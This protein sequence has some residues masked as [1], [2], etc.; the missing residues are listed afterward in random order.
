MKNLLRV[1]LV[2]VVVLGSANTPAQRAAS[3]DQ[4][5]GPAPTP[6]PAQLDTQFKTVVR[7]FIQT[8]CVTC[9]GGSGPEAG[10]DIDTYASVGAV[11]KDP[12]WSLV[13]ERIRNGEMPAREADRFPTDA[14]R[15]TVAE[16]FRALRNYEITRNA[17]DPGVVLARRL[18]NA[19][20]N[21]TIRDLT[22]VDLQPTR[23]FPSDPSNPAGFDNSGESLTMS[24]AL[25]NKYLKAARDIADHLYLQPDTFAF[26]PHLM[27]SESDRDKFCVGRII[28]FYHRQNTNYL[29]YFEAAWRYK[30]RAALGQPTA[31][32]ARVAA[33]AKV[34]AKYL[35][36]VWDTFETPSDTVGPIAKIQK[37]WRELPP[38]GP[39]KSDTAKQGREAIRDYI[40]RTRKK[41]EPRFA[42]LVA[43]RLDSGQQ[44]FMIWK[45]V[46]YATHRRTFDPA[47][48]QVNGEPWAGEPPPEQGTQSAF[49][50]GKTVFI[51]N[52]A[53]DPDLVVPAGERARYEAAFAKFAS[54][55]PDMFYM[56]E[57][58]RNYFDTTKDRGRYLDAGYHSILGYFRDDQALYE[59]ILEAKGQAE[60]DAMWTDMDFIASANARMYQQFVENGT[61]QAGTKP[62]DI[63]PPNPN[64]EP[65]TT[66]NRIN[67]VK[68]AY[69]K[70]AAGGTPQ[71]I[72]SIPE[73]FDWMNRTLR[74]IDRLKAESEPKHLDVLMKFAGRAYRRP[75]TQV[76]KN[77]LLAYYKSARAEGLNHEA[78]VR[79]TVTSILISP[80][81]LY[82]VDQAPGPG[83]QAPDSASAKATGERPSSKPPSLQGSKPLSDYA[84]ASRLSYF[85]WASM[86]DDKLLARAAA[87]DLHQPA[88]LM[89]EARRML[90]DP[91]ARALAVEFG[92]NWLNFRGFNDIGTVD[93]GRFPEFTND[94]KAAM[95]EEPVRLLMDVF[96]KNRSVLDLVYGTDTFVNAPLAK[97]Y[98]MPFD[99]AQGKPAPSGVEGWVHVTDANK[100]DRGGLLPM[101]A[102][103]TKNAPGLR[104][105]P[106]KRGN[107]VVKN[108]LGERISPPPP[109][110][111]QLPQDETK[112]EL[113]LRDTMARHRSDPLCS[114]CHAKFD[115]MGL[116]FEGFG[117]TGEKRTK[118]LAGRTVDISA[119]FPGGSQGAGVGG[120]RE[121]IR[122]HRQDDFVKNLSE[123]LLVY[124]LGR[125]LMLTDEPLIQ[126]I[127]RKMTAGGYHF[128][129]LIES[130]VTS[131]QFT[132]RR[133]AT[134]ER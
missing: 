86:P 7:P 46:Q 64:Q 108:V 134:G 33:E 67:L 89:A 71:A 123:K 115:A 74:R 114:G 128:S 85:L 48:L 101:A 16:W 104:T 30:H 68:E 66:E 120:L 92:G 82:R 88:V 80:D 69:I 62:L 40:V 107:W 100:D 110:V 87:G 56:Q 24:P 49:G 52:N 106:V 121:Y 11:V 5:R 72:A 23:E 63:I 116:V 43:G 53:G 129:T 32:L 77:D 18:S 20:L 118:D 42:N 29:D 17:G 31:T 112:L 122:G 50:P 125:S 97:H 99:F 113:S 65:P 45:N 8:Y 57:R 34:S 27:L 119:V 124:A 13:M 9:H 95:F 117:P 78:A 130:I 10:F 132:T 133:G 75:L 102:F 84:L 131:R 111:P 6:T 70:A 90:Q 26:A 83:P 3:P 12:R 55:F 47:Q 58:G 25:L 35:K 94:L 127:G 98:G 105:S 44:P 79:E 93:H 37:M 1:V 39:D 21:Y 59:L 76:E 38:P 14:E 19:E 96:Q 36:T 126:D 61:T 4:R 2:S 28:D 109:G 22:G 81:V 54:V 91:R 60:L 51:K 15:R 73:Y 103:L 41:I